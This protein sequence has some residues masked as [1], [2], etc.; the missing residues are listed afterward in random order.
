MCEPVTISMGV[1]AAVG[2]GL[3]IAGQSEQNKAAKGMEKNKQA[4]QAD[5]IEENRRRATKDYL[6]QVNAEQL[7]QRQ[8]TESVAEK[9]YDLMRQSRKTVATGMASAAERGVSGRTVDQIASDYNFQADL[10]IGRIKENQKNANIQHQ[11]K[12]QGFRD[13][14]DYR[15]S[16]VKPYTPKPVAPVDYFGPIFGAAAQT[17]QTGIGT[18]LIGGGKSAGSITS[19]E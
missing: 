11:R 19:K 3:N 12:L 17:V 8:E 6:R 10:E 15:A 5:L 18:G 16:A 14:Y 2:A 4:A 1:M 7:Q 9:S 13:E